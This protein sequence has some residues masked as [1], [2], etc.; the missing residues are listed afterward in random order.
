[1]EQIKQQ[2]KDFKAVLESGIDIEMFISV[3][4]STN[5]GPAKKGGLYVNALDSLGWVELYK[6]T[7]IDISEM[8][9][10]ILFDY[11]VKYHKKYFCKF[12]NIYAIFQELHYEKISLNLFE[13]ESIIYYSM[14]L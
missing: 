1:M 2:I 7:S 5:L 8:Q 3:L 9:L 11:M 10:L 4:K 12:N 6:S 13:L 14:T